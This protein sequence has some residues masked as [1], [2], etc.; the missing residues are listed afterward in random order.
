[1]GGE[2]S[3]DDKN[4]DD[5]AAAAA[6]VDDESPVSFAPFSVRFA[7]PMKLFGDSGTAA[8][9]GSVAFFFTLCFCEHVAQLAAP[10]HCL[11]CKTISA[12]FQCVSARDI[13]AQGCTAVGVGGVEWG[14]GASQRLPNQHEMCLEWAVY[15]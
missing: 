12:A 6:A 5:A 15:M 7:V 11:I 2:D 8:S 10:A 1:M 4:D 13:C 14:L 9:N 3:N